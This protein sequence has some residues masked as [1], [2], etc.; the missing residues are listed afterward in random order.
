MHA[1]RTFLEETCGSVARAFEQMAALAIRASPHSAGV[2]GEP[3]DRLKHKF[4]APEFAR[5]LS[6]MG[7]GVDAGGEWWRTL[8]RCVDVDEDGAVSL[9]DIYDALVLDLPSMPEY[10]MGAA[11]GSR[12]SNFSTPSRPQAQR[13]SQNGCFC[14][15]GHA[16]RP[17][18]QVCGLCGQKRP[19]DLNRDNYTTEIDSQGRPKDPMRTL[20]PRDA[21]GQ[22]FLNVGPA[23]GM[24]RTEFEKALKAGTYL[25]A[26]DKS[27]HPLY[28][29]HASASGRHA[30][31]DIE[32]CVCGSPFAP[33]RDFCSLCGTQRPIKQSA[34]FDKIDANKDDII[35]EAEFMQGLRAGV[36]RPGSS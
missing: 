21:P 8:F 27:E 36:I 20:D 10:E 32:I 25:P 12:S 15:C 3:E 35:N 26:N 23:D 16:L 30:R 2:S 22:G 34:V 9:Q 33:N 31:A 19:T 6:A 1:L 29:G 4:T 11:K 7:Y 18:D 14:S 17:Q 13:G 28:D 24:T 5:T